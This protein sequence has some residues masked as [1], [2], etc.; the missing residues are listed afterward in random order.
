MRLLPTLTALAA[1]TCSVTTLLGQQAKQPASPPMYQT[2][3]SIAE[4]AIALGR[5]VDSAMYVKDE[6]SKLGRPQT[7]SARR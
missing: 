4:K 3:T 5:D 7:G 6:M 2:I 1:L